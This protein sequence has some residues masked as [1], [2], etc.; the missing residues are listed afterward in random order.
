MI[1]IRRQ[2]VGL[3]SHPGADHGFAHGL[4]GPRYEL[5]VREF[6]EKHLCTDER[7]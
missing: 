1:L 3:K 4:E 2:R 7:I 6:L 5:R